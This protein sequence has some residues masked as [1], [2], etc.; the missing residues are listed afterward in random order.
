MDARV[1][2]I[3]AKGLLAIPVMLWA[4][5]A[6]DPGRFLP[7]DQGIR[8]A[9]YLLAR[10]GA[11]HVLWILPG[12]DNYSGE[13][14][15]KWKRI[16]RAVFE[17][18]EHAPV[19]LHPQGMQWPFDAY[20]D[21]K[22][23]GY[24]GYQSGHGDDADTM[25]WIHSGPPAQ[26]W[27]D[28]PHRPIVNLE[29]PYEDHVAYQSKQRHSPYNVRRA[30]YWS[31]LNAPTAGLTYGGH[32][33]WSW[34]TRPGE[35]PTDHGGTGTA[36]RWDQ[37]MDLPGSF[38]MT[39]LRDFIG[40]VEWWKLQPDPSVLDEQPG[41]GDPFR[42][43]SAARTEDRDTTILYLPVGGEVT[44]TAGRVTEAT[45]ADWFDPRTG[46]WREAQPFAS[47]RFRAPDHQD[48]LLLL[49]EHSR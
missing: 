16:G 19:T 46:E 5:G 48:W 35:T 44:L 24:Y 42:F 8:L 26:K 3:N 43:V 14:A 28:E 7:E 29:P 27:P 18:V 49:R 41:G 13:N 31:L 10:Y 6:N 45:Q 15:E 33:V 9:K 37:A 32:G 36:E 38:E 11:N 40:S 1:D 12:D 17:G 22:W 21:E 25:K 4:I 20:R 23:I 39:H 30:C 34:H 47:H 2:A